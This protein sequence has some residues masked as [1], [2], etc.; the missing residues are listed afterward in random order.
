MPEEPL[1]EGQPC[2]L[3]PHHWCVPHMSSVGGC[4]HASLSPDQPRSS[5]HFSTFGLLHMEHCELRRSSFSLSLRL[6]NHFSIPCQMTLQSFR[7][8]L[9]YFLPTSTLPSGNP[10][11]KRIAFSVL[12]KPSTMQ[13]H[14]S[15]STKNFLTRLPGQHPNKSKDSSV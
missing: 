13:A 14:T 5:C 2:I 9:V 8:V 12:I 6:N 4:L 15:S 3:Q 11:T 10:I 7:G 1:R